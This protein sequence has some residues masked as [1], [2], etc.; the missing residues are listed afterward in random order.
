MLALVLPDAV[1]QTTV[2]TPRTIRVVTDNVYAPY[3]FQSDAGELQGIVIDQWR[4]W[5]KKTGIKVEIYAMDWGEALRRMR[6]GEFDVIDAIVETPERREYFDFT[7]A[8][9]PI[10]ASVFFRNDISAITDIATLKGFP[11]GVKAGDQHVDK[12]KADGVTTVISFPNYDAMIDA[13]KQHKINVFVID[14]PSAL[15]LLNKA[16]IEDEFRHSAPMFHDELRRAVRK[17]DTALLRTVSDGFAAIEPDELKQINE[18]WFGRTINRIGQY[19][20]YAGYTACAALLII[21]GLTAWNRILR[22]KVL[23]RTAAL[24]ESEQRFRRLVELMPV[25]VYVCD[26]SGIIQSYN[27]RAVELWGRDPK[28]GD[29]AQRYCASLRLYSPDGSLVPHEES[30]MAEALRT[31]VP[32]HD[33]EVVIERPDGSRITVLVNIVPLRN[34]KGELVGAMNC[35]Q[36]ITERKRVEEALR[37][38]ERD[39]AEAQRVAKIGSW[40]FD[41]RTDLLTWSDELYRIFEIAKSDL[42]SYRSFLNRV[43]SEDKELVFQTSARAR[44]CGREF[45]IEYRI[46]S[47]SG[48]VKIIRELGF[49]SKDDQDNVKQ[50][51]G[52]A[53]DIT[54]RKRVELALDERLRFETLLTELSAA[55]ANLPTT[56]VDQEIDKWLQN[57]VEFLDLDRAIFDQVGEDGIT[58]SRSHSHTSRGIDTRPLDV[59]NDQAPWITE[60]LLRGNTVKWSRIPD[61]IPEQAWKEK[62]FTGRI[63]AKSVLSIPVCIGGAVICAVSFTSVRIY[64]DWPDEMVARLRL[65]GEIFANAVARKRVEEAL[66]RREA[67]LNEAQRLA[68]I[69][70]WEWDILTDGL[71][72]SDELRRIYGFEREDRNSPNKAFSEAIHRDDRARRNAAIRAALGGGPPYNVE[73]RIIRPDKSVRFVHSRGQ[74]IRDDAGKPVRMIGMAQDI[75]ERKRA[76]KELEKANHRLRLLSRR[77]FEVQEKERR[78]LARELHDEIGQALTAA[79]INLQAAMKEADG[80]KSK[81]IDETA[82]ILEKLLGQ[83][84]QISL[85][86]RPSML[87]DLGLVPALRSL[88][89]QQG[90]RASVAVHLSAKGMPENLDPEIQTTCF[91]I[92]QEAITNALRHS[93][94]TRIDVDLGRENGNFRLQVR[95]DGRGFDV[96][97]AQAQAVGLGLIGIKE[98]AALVGGRAKI[99]SSP[100]K[101][102]TIEVSLPLTFGPEG[103]GRNLGK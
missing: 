36:D 34:G 71:T 62:E 67:E 93:N 81:R 98:R 24:G 66:F 7:P 96:E 82:A 10:E 69:G 74:L 58:L 88:L 40:R 2:E 46:I 65:V 97:S 26:T 41:P 54:E 16:G 11:V 87:D 70:S 99:I 28:P 29:T 94:A 60:Q 27:N 35:F 21:A 101:G 64:R 84:R 76:A 85:D 100:N 78:H 79:K 103:R 39:L 44:E 12:L 49:V 32:A 37:A 25:A 13:A 42:N 6:A 4:A 38:R 89:V 91:R 86:L 30:K 47:Q 55:F 48:R 23:Q 22:K 77:L 15:Y 63:G 83:V 17:G 90:R 68:S 102:A 80:A 33:L 75:T 3:S 20:T 61:D 57:L 43:H 72:Y 50:L 31:G 52:V 5:E 51:F 9:T 18:K 73:F 8:Y 95:D 19:L 92:A 45:D 56:S 1:A 59:A 14:N 53:Q